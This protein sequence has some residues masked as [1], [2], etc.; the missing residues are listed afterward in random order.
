MTS[1]AI[2]RA[3]TRSDGRPLGV[4]L[5]VIATAQL[6]VVLEGNVGGLTDPEA[7]SFLSPRLGW[8]AGVVTSYSGTGHFRQDLRIVFTNDAGRT[9]HVRAVT[10]KAPPAGS[11]RARCRRTRRP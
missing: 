5:L 10:G 6:M 7:A 11:R 2:G 3:G 1:S 8:V 9:W 4:A